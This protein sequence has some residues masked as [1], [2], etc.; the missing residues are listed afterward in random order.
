MLNQI[1]SAL[2]FLARVLGDVNAI[3]RGRIAQRIVRRGVGRATGRVI[4]RLLR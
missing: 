2:Y 4:G 1:R 3:R